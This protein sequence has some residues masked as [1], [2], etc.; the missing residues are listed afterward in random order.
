MV[1]LAKIGSF[2][3]T[4]ASNW[5]RVEKQFRFV[6]ARKISEH[7]GCRYTALR[8]SIKY[9]FSACLVPKSLSQ[10]YRI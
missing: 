10:P 8:I 7:A 2:F 5:R 3:V 6:V 1:H 4:N 9:Y